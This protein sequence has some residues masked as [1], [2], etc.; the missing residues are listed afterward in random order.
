MENIFDRSV[1]LMKQCVT[2]YYDLLFWVIKYAQQC[3]S[4]YINT[5]SCVFILI[6]ENG[7]DRRR[8]EKLLLSWDPADWSKVLQ[9]F[10][11]YWE[12]EFRCENKHAFS[13]PQIW[14]DGF[15][16]PPV[17]CRCDM[18]QQGNVKYRPYHLGAQMSRELINKVIIG[19]APTG[20]SDPWSFMCT[21]KVT[22]CQKNSSLRY[23]VS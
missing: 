19:W 10:R 17:C 15:L 14:S 12:G 5:F 6:V 23:W 7:Y 4:K 20:D 3:F 2:D 1:V 21:L 11:G 8:Q 16:L 13:W 18:S 9:D 22:S